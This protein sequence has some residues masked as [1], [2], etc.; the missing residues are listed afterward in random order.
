MN[1]MK[2]NNLHEF[3][4]AKWD[5]LDKNNQSSAIQVQLNGAKWDD[6]TGYPNPNWKYI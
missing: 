2:N 6:E 5:K 4:G 3:N 1:N